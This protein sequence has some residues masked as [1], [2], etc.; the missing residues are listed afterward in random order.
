M[1]NFGLPAISRELIVSK[2]GLVGFQR[3]LAYTKITNPKRLKSILQHLQ[4]KV[5]NLEAAAE[6]APKDL[7][8]IRKMKNVVKWLESYM[9]PLGGGL[10]VAKVSCL[11]AKS[12]SS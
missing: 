7:D 1:E 5:E 11:P 6:K 2:T 3:I 12:P 10:C 4:I 9:Y 8:Y